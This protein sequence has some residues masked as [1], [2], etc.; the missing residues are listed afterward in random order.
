MKNSYWERRVS[1][2]EARCSKRLRIVLLE[3]AGSRKSLACDYSGEG[4]PG[5]NGRE[6]S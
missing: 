1:S 6:S 5:M 3:N 2:V 4:M